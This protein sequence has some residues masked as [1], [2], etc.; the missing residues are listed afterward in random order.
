[1]LHPVH[2]LHIIYVS[3]LSH[4]PNNG[5]GFPRG[6]A[7]SMRE[8]Q[9]WFPSSVPQAATIRHNDVCLSPCIPHFHDGSTKL[10]R[11]LWRGRRPRSA[12]YRKQNGPLCWRGRVVC[13]AAPQKGPPSPDRA[14][15][16][17]IA[18]ARLQPHH[19]PESEPPARLGT[20]AGNGYER[21]LLFRPLHFEPMLCGIR[22][23][24]VSHIGRLYTHNLPRPHALPP[25]VSPSLRPGF[26]H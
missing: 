20:D 22:Q 6:I 12:K 10:S 15:R 21:W 25:C 18:Q 24:P 13:T 3:G 26:L 8:N 2:I 17:H 9:N 16:P 14:I 4:F 19:G 11:T 1:M 7:H 23:T 5:S